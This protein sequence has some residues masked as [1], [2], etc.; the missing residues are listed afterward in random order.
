MFS[1]LMAAWTRVVTVLMEIDEWIVEKFR[2]LGGKGR[3][4]SLFGYMLNLRCISVMKQS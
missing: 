3:L 1:L 4:H 2:R